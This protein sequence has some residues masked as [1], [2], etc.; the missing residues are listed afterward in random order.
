MKGFLGGL[1]G[2]AVCFCASLASAQASDALAAAPEPHSV[3]AAPQLGDDSRWEERYWYGWQGAAIDAGAAALGIASIALLSTA[4]SENYEER[5]QTAQLLALV[6]AI[7]YG[8]GPPI[9]HLSHRQPW[10][11]LGSLGLRASLPVIGG[12]SGLALATCPHPGEEYG[13]CGMFE[14]FIGASTGA[15][16]AM[17]LDASVLAW[18]SPRAGARSGRQLGLAPI[19]TGDGRRELRVF[20]TF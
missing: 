5:E 12:A 7:A 20:G 16:L 4:G 11:A 8:A 18:E 6:G 10:Q 17:V 14:L 9:V 3:N 2:L 1:G 13:N 19:V 15:V